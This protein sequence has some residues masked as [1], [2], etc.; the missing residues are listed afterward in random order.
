LSDYDAFAELRLQL[1]KKIEGTRS[2]FPYL[3]QIVPRAFGSYYIDFGTSTSVSY[4]GQTWIPM[5]YNLF[6]NTNG[7]GFCGQDIG[8]FGKAAVVQSATGG[9]AVSNTFMY[10]AYGHR[11]EFFFAIANGVYNVTVGIGNPSQCTTYEEFIEVM[12][13]TVRNSSGSPCDQGVREYSKVVTITD[14]ALACAFGCIG[15]ECAYDA[16]ALTLLNYMTVVAISSSAPVPTP[17]VGAPT[18][19]S[20][21]P[22]PSSSSPT[23]T[24]AG[25]P[26]PA[27][28]AP[29]PAAPTPA[30]SPSPP[31][32]SSSS[33]PTPAQSHAAVRL[34]STFC[35]VLLVAVVFLL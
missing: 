26:T 25:S 27:S 21:S 7:I 10:D 14:G 18:P 35:A 11:N 23:P 33:T 3:T 24:V 17:S 2:D 31:T 30:A 5:M 6:D 9:S 1:G 19:S 12:G 15:G 20:S 22:T 32:P 16:S 4:N 28:S 8:P 34:L 13:V 29:T